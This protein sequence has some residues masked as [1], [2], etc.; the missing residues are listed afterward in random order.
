VEEIGWLLGVVLLASGY[1]LLMAVDRYVYPVCPSCS[2]DHDHGECGST[3]HGFATPLILAAA[4]HAFLDGW[5]ITTSQS[6]G[7]AGLRLS[8]PLALCLH[9]LP[10]GLALGAILRAS[11]A[12]RGLAFGWCLTAESATLLGAASGLA[13]AA[14][15]GGHWLHYPLAAAGGSFLYLGFHAIHAEWRARRTW[16]A[17]LPGATG[18]AGAAFLQHGVR[19]FLR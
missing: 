12:S 18:A 1:V 19:A 5:G 2:H 7:A 3:L 13:M 10:E 14:R 8:L 4:F 6:A 17:F 15:V 16:T 11:M 9:K